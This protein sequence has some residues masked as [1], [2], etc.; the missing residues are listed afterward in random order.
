VFQV[1]PQRFPKEIGVL[2]GLVGAAGGIGGFF[3]PNLLGVLKKATG[4]YGYGFVAFAA[5][6]LVA[7]VTVR[8]V[9]WAWEKT[10]APAPAATPEPEP[11]LARV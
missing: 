9:A 7:A 2:T 6:A 11:V 3:L 1:V 8:I 5:V 10:A 4:S